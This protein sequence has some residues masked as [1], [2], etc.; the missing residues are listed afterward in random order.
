M[1]LALEPQA[2]GRGRRLHRLSV[3]GVSG[4]ASRPGLSAGASARATCVGR[5]NIETSGAEM[6]LM[7]EAERVESQGRQRTE[8]LAYC[9]IRGRL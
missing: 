6:M 2:A 9:I 1:S 7:M 3:M 8:S 4:I 5:R